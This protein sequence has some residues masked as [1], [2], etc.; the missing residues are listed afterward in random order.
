MFTHVSPLES[1]GE[2]PLVYACSHQ[3]QIGGSQLACMECELTPLRVGDD[4]QLWRDGRKGKG[5]HKSCYKT[6][7]DLMAPNLHKKL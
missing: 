6:I 4:G 5:R 7:L 1:I 3:N 2:S